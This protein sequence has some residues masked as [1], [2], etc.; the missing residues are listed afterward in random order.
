MFLPERWLPK[1]QRQEL[2][3]EIF[4]EDAPFTLKQ[5]AFLA[6]SCGPANCIGKQLA[7]MEIRMAICSLLHEFDFKFAP[8]YDPSRY[9]DDFRDYYIAIRG[10][11]PVVLDRR[12]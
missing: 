12:T 4:C 7:F 11:L 1:E 10:P 3:P 2:E 6:F 5:A 9:E 8:G